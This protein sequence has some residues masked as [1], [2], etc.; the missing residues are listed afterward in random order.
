MEAKIVAVADAYE[1]M[2][3]DRVYRRSIGERAAREELRRHSGTQFDPRVVDA[4]LQVLA[5]VD[6]ADDETPS[7]VRE[8][9]SG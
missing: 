4:F 7:Q 2:T 6:Q 3:S 8:A 5:T 1:A 9:R